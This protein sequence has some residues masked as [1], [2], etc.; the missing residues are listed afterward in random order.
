[1]KKAL[2]FAIFFIGFLA[3]SQGVQREKINGKIIHNLWDK[4][5][6]FF[7]DKK[8]AKARPFIYIMYRFLSE[9]KVGM[10]DRFIFIG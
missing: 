5:F 9:K 3:I 4:L 8:Y 10:G 6:P 7:V 1:M 2:Q